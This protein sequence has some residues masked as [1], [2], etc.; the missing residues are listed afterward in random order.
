MS[1]H[2]LFDHEASSCRFTA[3]RL[4]P[5]AAA[6]AFCLAG[7]T[8]AANIVVNDSSEGSVAGMCTLAD[9]VNALNTQLAVNGCIAGDGN[10]DTIDLT[11]FK[12]PTAITFTANP[13]AL[14]HVLELAA[15]ATL[16]GSLDENGVPYVTIERS[17][18]ANTPEFGLIGTTGALTIDGLILRNGAS[19]NGYSGG[20]IVTGSPLTLSRSIVT[21]NSSSSGGGGIADTDSV[22]LYRSEISNNSAAYAGGGIQTNG[23]VNAYYSTI[24]DNS[25]TDPAGVGGGIDATDHVLIEHSIVS[26]NQSGLSGGGIAAN[27][28]VGLSESILSGN[29]A[30]GG[31]GG[32]VYVDGANANLSRTTLYSNSAAMDGG[33]V[34]ADD[35][36]MT[37][38]TITGNSA[39]ASGGGIHAQTAT[40]TYATIFANSAQSG[41]G[42]YIYTSA[43]ATGTIIYG[44]TPQ[45][46]QSHSAV[47]LGGSYDLLGTSNI[48]VPMGTLTCDPMLGSLSDNGGATLT[49]PLLTGSCAIDAAGE[50][51][52]VAT[53]QRGYSRPA[54]VGDTL[55]A[56]IGAYEYGSSDPDVIFANG[57]EP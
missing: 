43:A 50:T 7:S 37:N 27:G 9:A 49:L 14:S 56:D 41:G 53:D 19:T 17:S 54:L 51:P 2:R 21:G 57:F 35:V 34:F 44:N 1:T 45:D 18:V 5:L 3:R 10:D 22:T 30:Q 31:S 39:G 28:A 8:E 11:G 36:Q 25:T 15:R 12:V 40:I 6:I 26:G 42:L 55:K 52:T 23:S 4:A 47:P 13:A 33:A 32:A 48:D 24:R 38:S 29:T 16:V 46:V 20:A